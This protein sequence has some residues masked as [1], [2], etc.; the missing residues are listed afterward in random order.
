MNESEIH[1]ELKQIGKYILKNKGCQVIGE[2]IIV[3]SSYY[4]Q[5][6]DT[7]NKKVIYKNTIDLLGLKVKGTFYHYNDWETQE[8]KFTEPTIRCIGIESKASLED[9]KNGFC[10]NPEKVYIIAPIG[11]IPK[12]LIPPKI[13]LIE[14]DLQNYK[15][16]KLNTGCYKLEGVYETVKAKY[17]PEKEYIGCNLD[18]DKMYQHSMKD[19]LRFIAY[20]QTKLDLD[21]HNQI[22]ID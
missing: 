11:I 15:I 10:C 22:I 16:T 12:E 3:D 7:F 6:N 1:Y 20:R 8:E 14:V 9:F 2:E 19:H 13:G 18:T 21:K 5:N 4:L 17:K